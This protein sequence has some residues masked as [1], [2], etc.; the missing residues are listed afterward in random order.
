MSKV[1]H[2]L[3]SKFRRTAPESVSGARSPVR[4]MF[5]VIVGGMGVMLAA[6]VSSSQSAS[7]IRLVASQSDMVAGE[8]FSV[9]IS[10]FAHIPV[11]AVD[12]SLSYD[13]EKVSVIGVDRGRSVITLWTAEPEVGNGL[14]RLQGGTYRRGF[15]DEHQIAV[16]NFE[17]K[18]N[19][20]ANFLLTKSTFL[21]GDG[22]GSEVPIARTS[23]SQT[24]V[25]IATFPSEGGEISD[26][27]TLTLVTDLD[28]DGKVTLADISMFMAGWGKQDTVYD[29]TGDGKMTFRDFSVL[30]AQYFFGR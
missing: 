10:A 29:F 12:M 14:I 23:L 20:R 11:N 1:W 22:A 25:R 21:A 4:Y 8:R 9:T 13:Q 26:N 2:A 28:G 18:K 6:V 5:P 3:L 27:V 17:A 24:E 7:Y 15:I 19:G 30:L 16:I